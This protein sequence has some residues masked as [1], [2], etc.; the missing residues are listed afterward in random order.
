M[1]E[2]DGIICV[3]VY[4]DDDQADVWFLNMAFARA[5][6]D[7]KAQKV[8]SKV[9]KALKDPDK[10][11]EMDLSELWDADDNIWVAPPCVVSDCVTI[12]MEH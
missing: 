7:P 11:E 5:S 2:G 8:F 1:I 12:Y 10:M 4:P 3:L 6:T 9:S